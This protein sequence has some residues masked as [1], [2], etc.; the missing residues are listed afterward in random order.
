MMAS[1]GG[2]ID[3]TGDEPCPAVDEATADRRSAQ[4]TPPEED[5]RGVRS[6]LADDRETPGGRK[7]PHSLH[8]VEGADELVSALTAIGCNLEETIATVVP[9]VDRPPAL[10]VGSIA[11]GFGTP[12]S[13]LDILVLVDSLDGVVADPS[14]LWLDTANSRE[15]LRYAEG[16]EI[17][18]T[19]MERAGFARLTDALVGVAPALYDPGALK[20]LPMI[21]KEDLRWGHRL[22][23]GW[24]LWG[25]DVV[26]Q[27][28][29]EALLALL[30]QYLAVH[31]FVEMSEFVEDAGAFVGSTPGADGPRVPSGLHTRCVRRAGA[32]WCHGPEPQ[33]ARA[34]DPEPG[35]GDVPCARP[36]GLRPDPRS[37][38][39]GIIG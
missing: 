3:A 23:S 26:E 28:R 4:P 14:D 35:R 25:H 33:V 37:R 31:H 36:G 5:R 13:D 27:W 21:G 11:E 10:V 12:A 18:F 9:G 34:H 24:P 17:N 2:E 19:F 30:P 1:N 38:S 7:R 29:D 32:R 39:D 20:S 6:G 22:R 16:L 15:L 8:L